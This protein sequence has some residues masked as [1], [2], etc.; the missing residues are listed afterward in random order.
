M[1]S[2]AWWCIPVVSALEKQRQVDL[3]KFQT[4]LVYRVSPR[5]VRA[6][7]RNPASR[8]KTKTKR[9]SENLMSIYEYLEHTENSCALSSAN[10][11]QLGI[12]E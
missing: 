6:T 4:S 10:A 8:N 7:K 9:T 5:T 3:Y 2:R 11:L 12:S 1:R